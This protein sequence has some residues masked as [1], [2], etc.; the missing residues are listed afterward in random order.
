MVPMLNAPVLWGDTAAVAATHTTRAVWAID[1]IRTVHAE[2]VRHILGGDIAQKEA[3]NK[4]L[5]SQE[6]IITT[7]L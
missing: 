4:Q 1:G 6:R 7:K 3:I 2:R 5:M